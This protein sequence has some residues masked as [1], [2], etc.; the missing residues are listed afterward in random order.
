[1]YILKF[2]YN[3]MERISFM[4]P[5][6]GISNLSILKNTTFIITTAILHF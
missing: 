6:I 5:L 3:D 1:M 4:I 2:H